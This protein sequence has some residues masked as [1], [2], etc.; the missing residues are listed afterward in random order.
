MLKKLIYTIKWKVTHLGIR[1]RKSMRGTGVRLMKD[2]QVANC[3][4]VNLMFLL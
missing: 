4:K 1:L 3:I 2:I